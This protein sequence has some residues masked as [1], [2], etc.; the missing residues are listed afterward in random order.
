MA[1]RELLWTSRLML[2]MCAKLT[3]DPAAKQV[4]LT[5]YNQVKQKNIGNLVNAVKN[6]CTAKKDLLQPA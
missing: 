2:K 4:M 1:N 6:F 3:Q 5:D